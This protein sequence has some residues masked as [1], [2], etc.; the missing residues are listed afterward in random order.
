MHPSLALVARFMRNAANRKKKRTEPSTSMRNWRPI[1]NR[2]GKIL[3][4]KRVYSYEKKRGVEIESCFGDIKHN[5]EFR[6]FHLRGLQ[7]VKTEWNMVAMA[8]NLRKI[9]LQNLRKA[10]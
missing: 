7:K 4:V 2:Q 1:N 6:R 3:K 5:M 9:Y 10:A 8:H